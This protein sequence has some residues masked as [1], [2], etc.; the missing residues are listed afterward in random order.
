MSCLKGTKSHCKP[1]FYHLARGNGKL[2]DSSRWENLQQAQTPRLVSRE[3][4]GKTMLFILKTNK[5]TDFLS[6][7]ASLKLINPL[8]KNN[9]AHLN[10]CMSKTW[11]GGLASF[12]LWDSPFIGWKSSSLTNPLAHTLV[13]RTF[14]QLAESG[15]PKHH[16]L[17]VGRP[18]GTKSVVRFL[19]DDLYFFVKKTS[20]NILKKKNVFF[21]GSDYLSNKMGMVCYHQW[22]GERTMWE[23]TQCCFQ[24]IYGASNS[25]GKKTA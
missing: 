18:R 24:R 16:D 8:N 17:A 2:M 4:W 11:A 7:N 20:L 25:G 14:V 19:R 15:T 12:S 10:K 22:N 1:I 13:W 21:G 3:N 5:K 6:K 9:L 23:E